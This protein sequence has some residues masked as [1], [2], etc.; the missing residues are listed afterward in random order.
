MKALPFL[1]LKSLKL[2]LVFCFSF[3]GLNQSFG[4]HQIGSDFSYE[5]TSTPGIYNVTAKIY[6]DC[7]GVQLCPNCPTA[8]SSTCSIS[9]TISG[10]GTYQGTTFGSATLSIIPTQSAYDVVAICSLSKTICSNCGTRTAGTFSPG[11]EVYT[12]Q[13]TLN[14]NSLPAAACLVRLSYNSC[15]RN[16]NISAMVAP[17]FTNFFSEFMLNR[18]ITP[19]NSSPLTS[20]TPVFV[21]CAGADQSINLST[22][23]PDGDSLSYNFAPSL[24]GPSQAVAYVSPYSPT[25]PF[26]YLGPPTGPPYLFPAGLYLS[27]NTGDLKFRPVGTFMAN[28]VI[29]TKQWVK[30]LGVPTLAG[31]I[32]RDYQFISKTCPANSPVNIK[33]FDSLGV[34]LGYIGFTNDTVSIQEGKP[35]CRTYVASDTALADTTDFT[36]NTIDQM[37]GASVSKLYNP[38]TRSTIG[39]RQDSIKFCWTPP[40][41]SKRELAYYF[42]FTAK[43][44]VCPIPYSSTQTLSIKVIGRIPDP[45]HIS[46]MSYSNPKCV[47]DSSGKLSVNISE[48]IPPFIYKLNQGNYQST[49]IF[50]KLPA[51][52]YTVYAMD[53][54]GTIDSAQFTLFDPSALQV[55][56]SILSQTPIACKYDSTGIATLNVTNGKAPFLFYEIGKSV[57]TSP[58]FSGLPAGNTTFIVVDSNNCR[59]SA[60][61]TIFE[62]SLALTA[63]ISTSNA[64]C[65]GNNG[66]YTINVSGGVSPYTYSTN[67]GLSFDSISSNNS[68]S[69]GNYKFQIKDSNNCIFKY[70]TDITTPSQLNLSTVVSSVKCKGDSTGS[71][72]INA[73]GGIL[74][75]KYAIHN[76]SYDSSSFFSK[77]IAG[78]YSV[79]LLDS[80]NCLATENNILITE[81]TSSLQASIVSQD[82]TCLGATNGWAK[83][84]VQGGTLPYKIGWSTTPIRYGD[85]IG[86]LPAGKVYV[87]VI[88]TNF[89]YAGDST[90][91]GY[92]PVYNSEVICA[93][94]TDTASGLHAL[95]WNKTQDMG[96]AQYRIYGSLTSGSGFTLLDSVLFTGNS[97]YEDSEATRLNKIYYYQLSAVDSC[98]NESNASGTQSNLFVTGQTIAGVNQLNWLLPMGTMGIQ[99][100]LIWR[101]NNGAAFTQIANLPAS[102]TTF[103]DSILPAGEYTYFL[104][105]NQNPACNFSGTSQA[106]FT[107][108]SVLLSINTG[109]KELA[110]PKFY[111]IYPNPSSGKLFIIAN[112][113]QFGI[114]AVEIFNAQGAKVFAQNYSNSQTIE[115]NMSELAAGIY[116]VKVLT[117]D[118]GSQSTKVVLTK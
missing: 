77:L 116:H 3:F 13:G 89:C 106:K 64:S 82:A 46:N 40:I 113:N 12:Y 22:P 23:D 86:L 67:D 63:T 110:I 36:W 15:C 14:L 24:N 114:E 4:A 37:P 111:T 102:S 38:A 28:L 112:T 11:V 78:T 97:V 7:A 91:I 96:I 69:I 29:E 104:E 53:S 5:C 65:W 72:L 59:D 47:G 76:G 117:K 92:K 101:S 109:I 100:I 68:A 33:K 73:S 62:P 107:S 42:I 66:S 20:N 35:F 57:Q 21:M 51:G 17:S 84:L 25:E 94:N 27:I 81:P 50:N 48:G 30:V 90:I 26:P 60:I 43:D 93:I 61:A 54:I 79:S 98:G 99:N 87:L 58:I 41:N 118:N 105:L 88:D 9:L 108:N 56:L 52:S 95:I 83:V 70:Q 39:P 10:T 74:P 45:I 8:L 115:I 85:S 6:R 71:I 16:S 31:S 44:R 103:S 1:D 19:C 55:S 80:N 2:Y 49:N 75:Y 32:R 34:N 18:C